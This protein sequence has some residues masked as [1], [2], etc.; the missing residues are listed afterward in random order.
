MNHLEKSPTTMYF[1]AALAEGSKKYECILARIHLLE[2][3]TLEVTPPLEQLL[4]EVDKHETALQ[5]STC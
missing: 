1:G 3:G 2:D 5:N 4:A